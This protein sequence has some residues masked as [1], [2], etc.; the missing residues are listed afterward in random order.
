LQKAGADKP[1]FVTNSETNVGTLIIT[2]L[3]GDKVERTMDFTP[4]QDSQQKAKETL[5][6]EVLET[7]ELMR[8]ME[9]SKAMKEE[10]VNKE[11]K[12]RKRGAG[13][14]GRFLG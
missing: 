12:K 7:E 3:T 8:L 13:K 14:I 11:T 9:A 4:G 10:N 2:S 1:S 6:A 5:A